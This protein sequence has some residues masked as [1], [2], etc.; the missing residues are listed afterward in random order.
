M[1]KEYIPSDIVYGTRWYILW[2]KLPSDV[3]IINFES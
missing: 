1:I 3:D 2:M